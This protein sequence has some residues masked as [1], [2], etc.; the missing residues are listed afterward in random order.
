MIEPIPHADEADI[1][2]QTRPVD[3]GIDECDTVPDQLGENQDADAADLLDQ[4]LS[5][6]GQDDDDPPAAG[7]AVALVTGRVF[8][9]A[10]S[11]MTSRVIAAAGHAAT[12]SSEARRSNVVVTPQD[13]EAPIPMMPTTATPE[14]S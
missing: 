12:T 7:R 3:D 11:F 6:S 8:W 9:P 2:E 14:R 5:V 4:K 1:A 10:C 13:G